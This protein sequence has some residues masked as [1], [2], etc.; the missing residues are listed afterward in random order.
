MKL[1]FVLASLAA[2]TTLPVTGDPIQVKVSPIESFAY[3]GG[4]SRYGDLEFRGGLVI[5]SREK[6][7]GGW[8]GIEVLDGGRD[9]VILSD[10][11]YLLKARLDYS[12]GR[13]SGL[14]VTNQMPALPGKR[15]SIKRNDSEDLAIGPDNSL[16][17]VLEEDKHQLAVRPFAKGAWGKPRMEAVPGARRVF[18][19]NKGL[20]SIAVIPPGRPDAGRMLAIA[21]RPPKRSGAAIPC[22]IFGVGTCSIVR[23]DGFEITSARFLPDGDLVILERRLAPGF[24]LA[25]RLRRIPGSRIGGNAPMDG[26]IILEGDL[27][28]QI[29]NMEGL[30][31]HVDDAGQTIL[32]LVSDDN[33]NVFQRTL[34]LQ[35]AIVAE[36][37]RG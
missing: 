33:Q 15:K 4:G 23:R 30:A 28:K 17:I 31:V 36:G 20:E 32:T 7:F 29:D 10:L 13:L 26:K 6:T 2:A 37:H 9:A 27:S 21:E 16:A 19:I 34:M 35:F 22:W 3:F 25:M 18:G 8:S 12:N 11:G 5:T 1:A 24:D 14:E